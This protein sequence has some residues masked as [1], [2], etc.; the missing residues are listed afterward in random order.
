[1]VLKFIQGDVR[2]AHFITGVVEEEPVEDPVE[3][4]VEATPLPEAVEATPVAGE[5]VE[6]PVE[7]P[8]DFDLWERQQIEDANLNG[9]EGLKAYADYMGITLESRLLNEVRAEILEWYDANF[10]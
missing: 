2:Y 5:A 7:D 8:V 9:E 1:M 3:D 6:E 4:P 10:G